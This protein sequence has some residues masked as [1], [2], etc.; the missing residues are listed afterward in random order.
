LEVIDAFDVAQPIARLDTGQ[1]DALIDR[2]N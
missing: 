2:R 1:S